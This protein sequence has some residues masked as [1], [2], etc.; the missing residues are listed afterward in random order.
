V[1]EPVIAGPTGDEARRLKALAQ[2][3]PGNATAPYAL[4]RL[5]ADQL[6]LP[7]AQ[8]W[9]EVSLARDPLLAQA[10]YLHGLIL[11]ELGRLEESLEALRSSIY[12]DPKFL[13][14]HYSIAGLYRRLGEPQRAAKALTTLEQLLEGRDPHAEIPDGDGLTIGRLA[15]YAAAQK[16]ML[17]HD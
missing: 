4:A 5:L 1:V 13:M 12:V 10:H 8:Q 14:G 3:E 6:D 2:A 7:A 11:M 17:A 16:E 15:A 9:V